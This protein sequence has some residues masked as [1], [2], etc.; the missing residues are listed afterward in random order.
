[1]TALVNRVLHV[2][3]HTLRQ[4]SFGTVTFIVMTT[5]AELLGQSEKQD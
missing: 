4:R 3:E 2:Q 5:C 1:M